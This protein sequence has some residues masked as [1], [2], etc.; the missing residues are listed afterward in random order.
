MRSLWAEVGLRPILFWPY[1]V[2]GTASIFLSTDDARDGIQIDV[3]HDPLGRGRYGF[4][5]GAMLDHVIPGQMFPRLDPETTRTYLARKRMVK[6]QVERFRLL[7]DD[8][9]GLPLA[10]E[11]LSPAA[12]AA[13]KSAI[14]ASAIRPRRFVMLQP[15]RWGR[16]LRRPIGAWV[17]VGGGPLST[18]TA[19]GVAVR[20]ERFIPHVRVG[21]LPPLW[22]RPSWWA[23]H[24]APIRWRPGVFVSH[25]P[26]GP[27]TP[28]RCDVLVREADNTDHACQQIVDALANRSVR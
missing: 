12:A 18:S 28:R 13:V 17:H 10:D 16:R 7:T 8:A 5:S 24:V 14:G 2:D 20:L 6:G 4:R 15:A 25:D 19:T 27:M 1:D 23:W 3:L 26:D 22:R 21:L 11:I 9:G